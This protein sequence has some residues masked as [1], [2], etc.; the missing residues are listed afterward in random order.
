VETFLGTASV[1]M[2]KYRLRMS[3][4][5]W[6]RRTFEFKVEELKKEELHWPSL[7]TSLSIN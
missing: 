2:T 4:E 1:H 5:N 3:L 6:L 7:N